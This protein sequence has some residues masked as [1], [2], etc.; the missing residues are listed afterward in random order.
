[1]VADTQV[2]APTLPYRRRHAASDASWAA[3]ASRS[4]VNKKR[5]ASS[6]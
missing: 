3:W 6:A 1:V 4:F 5:S 2:A